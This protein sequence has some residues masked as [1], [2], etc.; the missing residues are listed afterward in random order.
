[1]P[2]RIL[3]KEK[4]WMAWNGGGKWGSHSASLRFSGRA[5]CSSSLLLTRCLIAKDNTRLVY[6]SLEAVVCDI[7]F[8]YFGLMI[9]YLQR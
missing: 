5:C 7:P 9:E 4:G 3:R 8:C 1:M 6:F 2:Y